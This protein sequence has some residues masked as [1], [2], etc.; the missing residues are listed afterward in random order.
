MVQMVL[1]G[2]AGGPNVRTWG[3]VGFLCLDVGV[4]PPSRLVAHGR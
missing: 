3:F 4:I 1:A 2:R